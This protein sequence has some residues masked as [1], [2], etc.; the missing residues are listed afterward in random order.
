MTTLKVK[1]HN[2]WRKDRYND[3]PMPKRFVESPPVVVD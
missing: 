2:I 1:A 3:W